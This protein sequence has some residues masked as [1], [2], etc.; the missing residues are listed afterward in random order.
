M[1]P[2]CKG[3]KHEN[4][5]KLGNYITIEY[6]KKRPVKNSLATSTYIPGFNKINECWTCPLRFEYDQYIRDSFVGPPSHW[7]EEVGF[8][9]E[10][11]VNELIE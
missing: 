8:A 11:G 2:P 5:T 4:Q 3:C 1:Q 9:Y 10:A 7:G 6:G